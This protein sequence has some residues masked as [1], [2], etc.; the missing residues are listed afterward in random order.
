MSSCQKTDKYNERLFMPHHSIQVHLSI[1]VFVKT[2]DDFTL[3][4]DF[5]MRSFRDSAKI[6]KLK[7]EIEVVKTPTYLLARDEDCE[8]A[9]HS[10]AD[11]VRRLHLIISLLNFFIYPISNSLDEYVLS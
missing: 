2:D 3:L 9:F 1:R 4:I 8:N 5:Q 7:S 11:F 6:T 10:T